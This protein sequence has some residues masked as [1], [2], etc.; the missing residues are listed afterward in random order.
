M[1]VVDMSDRPSLVTLIVRLCL[2]ES[3]PSALLTVYARCGYH[4]NSVRSEKRPLVTDGTYLSSQRAVFLVHADI[5]GTG[6]RYCAIK[7]N[8]QGGN[9]THYKH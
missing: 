6:W 3:S 1:S 9:V 7:A 8:S 2:L 4:V 5:A